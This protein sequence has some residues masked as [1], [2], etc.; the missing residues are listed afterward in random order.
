M[1]E[2]TRCSEGGELVEELR[3]FLLAAHSGHSADVQ[4]QVPDHPAC[5]QLTQL[6]DVLHVVDIVDQQVA[7][8][9]TGDKALQK[10]RKKGSDRK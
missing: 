7:L 2:C 6:Q 9:H 5:R 3:V 8:V 10:E 4:R 1:T